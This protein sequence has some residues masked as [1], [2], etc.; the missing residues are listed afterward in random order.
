[1]AA[2][3]IPATGTP[4]IP[5]LVTRSAL[6]MTISATTVSKLLVISVRSTLSQKIPSLAPHS[7]LIIL[8]TAGPEVC[9]DM[10]KR[11]KTNVEMEDK[12]ELETE[13]RGGKRTEVRERKRGNTRVVTEKYSSSWFAALPGATIQLDSPASV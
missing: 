8:A 9:G 10:E 3:V 6:M 2:P 4:E 12:R 7:Q 5:V 11:A 1:M 13:V